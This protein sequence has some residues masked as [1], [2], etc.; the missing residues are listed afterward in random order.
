M[1]IK[2]E[3]LLKTLD[4]THKVETTINEFFELSGTDVERFDAKECLL[5][6]IAASLLYQNHLLNKRNE[7]IEII[8]SK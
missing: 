4:N 3:E 8:S 2:H 1:K 5:K 7:L 6:M